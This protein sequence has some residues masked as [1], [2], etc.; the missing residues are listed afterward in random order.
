[1]SPETMQKQMAKWNTWLKGLGEKGVLKN[2]GQPLE[3][4]GKLV[5]NKGKTVTDGLFAEA[6]D[7]IGG[8]SI[9]E[10]ENID[11]AVEISKGCPVLDVGG[12][13]EVRPTMKM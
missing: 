4:S 6:K 13:V 3:R 12:Q 9:I 10:A 1:M 8:Y 5:G 11:Q 2:V 7:I